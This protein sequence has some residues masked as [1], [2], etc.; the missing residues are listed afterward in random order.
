MTDVESN[1]RPLVE[2]LE[3]PPS[4]KTKVDPTEDEQPELEDTAEVPNSIPPPAAD[5]ALPTEEVATEEDYEEDYESSEPID[6]DDEEFD[7]GEVESEDDD[8]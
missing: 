4:K 6:E 1:K 7:V 3:E 2:E 8:D 5:D